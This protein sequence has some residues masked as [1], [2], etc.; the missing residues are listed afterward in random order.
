MDQICY[1]PFIQVLACSDEDTQCHLNQKSYILTPNT[2]VVTAAG[3]FQAVGNVLALILVALPNLMPPEWVPDWIAGPYIIFLV[4]CKFSRLQIWI[5]KQPVVICLSAPLGTPELSACAC[6]ALFLFSH[7][8]LDPMFHTD[9]C[10]D[11]M[12]GNCGLD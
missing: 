8:M 10:Y 2:C 6:L 12:C 11:W 1:S 7:T 9:L 3:S 5:S 4:T